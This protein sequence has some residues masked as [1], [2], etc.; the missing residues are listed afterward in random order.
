M[1]ARLGVVIITA[2]LFSG[3]SSISYKAEGKYMPEENIERTLL[4]QWK[5]QKYYIPFMNNEVDYGSVSFQEEC[6]KN[7]LLDHEINK[8]YGLIFKERP[9]DFKVVE[10]AERIRLGNYIVCAKLKNNSSLDTVKEGNISFQI[11][12]E[13]KSGVPPI[14][15]VNLD[16]YKL[17]VREAAE[18]ISLSCNQQ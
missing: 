7:T 14:T 17:K 6:R 3:C 10:S 11:L 1:F 8:D 12:C 15:P 4:L 18:H 5:A 16:G 13:A 2:I 9:Q